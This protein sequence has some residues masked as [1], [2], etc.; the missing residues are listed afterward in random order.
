MKDIFGRLRLEAERVSEA[1]KLM[2][3]NTRVRDGWDLV[4]KYSGLAAQQKVAAGGVALSAGSLVG[5]M[6]VAMANQAAAL[7]TSTLLGTASTALAGLGT[8]AVGATVLPVATVATLGASVTG[9][10]ILAASKLMRVDNEKGFAFEEAIRGRD[11]EGL[12]SL[13]KQ[14]IG[15]MDWIKGARNFLVGSIKQQFFGERAQAVSVQN[16]H[17][18]MLEYECEDLFA[19]SLEE[20][21]LGKQALVEKISSEIWDQHG[22]VVTDD[23]IHGCLGKTRDTEVAHGKILSVDKERGLVLQS[24]GRGQATVHSLKDFSKIPQIGAEMTISYRGGQMR[25]L[26]EKDLGRGVGGSL[27]R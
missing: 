27:G 11:G 22:V 10:A 1:N 20:S 21:K 6:G 5:M 17:D 23:K 8:V 4:D 3:L 24:I 19:N 7:G 2:L 16:K 13:A 12:K 18:A 25:N 14:D 9:I 26:P 15:A